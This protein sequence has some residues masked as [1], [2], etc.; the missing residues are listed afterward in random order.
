MREWMLVDLQLLVDHVLHLDHVQN[1][2][3]DL[4]H[5]ENPGESYKRCLDREVYPAESTNPDA[6]LCVQHMEDM[7]R[8]GE[9]RCTFGTREIHNT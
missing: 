4:I 2:F 1:L 6:N 3:T 8:S 5:V 9:T 7:H